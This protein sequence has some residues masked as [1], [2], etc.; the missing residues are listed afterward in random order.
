MKYSIEVFKDQK[1]IFI[2]DKLGV[3]PAYLLYK[4][5][6]EFTKGTLIKDKVT[7]RGSALLLSNT[8]CKKIQ[9]NLISTSALEILES[10]KIEVEYKEIV[11]YIIN[12][13]GDGKCPVE[14]LTE[15]IENLD[16]ALPLIENFL[17]K[18]WGDEI[19]EL[20]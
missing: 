8:G 9:T 2:S 17:K 6:Y 14:I 12:R 19:N 5:G 15:D 1:R 11:P 3:L 7:G 18:I 16:E 13:T 4:K 10:K 20:S